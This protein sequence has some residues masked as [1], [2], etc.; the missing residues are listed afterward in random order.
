MF[1]LSFVFMSG[2]AAVAAYALVVFSVGVA[3]VAGASAFLGRLSLE[4]QGFGTALV[5][6]TMV[7]AGWGSGPTIVALVNQHM[8]GG[9]RQ[10]GLAIFLVGLSTLL[11]SLLLFSRQVI[12]GSPLLSR[13][14]T[15][16]P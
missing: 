10:I 1:G 5:A 6:F 16:R 7:M 14:Q 13:L 9:D 4:M 2:S 12:V 3:S 15:S 8:L 11:F